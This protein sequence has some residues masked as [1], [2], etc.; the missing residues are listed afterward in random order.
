MKQLLVTV[1]LVVGFLI[2][3]ASGQGGQTYD[4][5]IRLLIREQTEEIRLLRKAVGKQTSSI[6][7]LDERL[8]DFLKRVPRKGRKSRLRKQRLQPQRQRPPS[9]QRTKRRPKPQPFRR[10]SKLKRR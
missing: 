4:E 7:M 3:G 6:K 9:F 2:L 8:T 5:D 1:V 10:P